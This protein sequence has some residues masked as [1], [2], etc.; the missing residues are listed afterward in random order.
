MDRTVC[1]HFNRINDCQEC[2]DKIYKAKVV[3]EI[4]TK[5][6]NWVEDSINHVDY[7]HAEKWVKRMGS[8]IKNVTIIH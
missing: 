1:E 8:K 7:K 6:G 5:L 2:E 4:Q 3:F